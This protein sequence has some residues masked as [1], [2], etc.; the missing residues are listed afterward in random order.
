[1]SC[2][3]SFAANN[4]YGLAQCKPMPVGDYAWVEEDQLQKLDF[5]SMTEDQ[6]QGYI[7]EVTL[8]YPKSLHQSHGSFPLAPEHL[9]LRG[10]MLSEYA[11]GKHL[12]PI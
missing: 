4:L 7:V 9:T 2:Y 12:A 10:D 11:S 3:F 8:D 1:M 6:E 5:S